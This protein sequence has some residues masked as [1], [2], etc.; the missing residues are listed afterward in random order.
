[1]SYALDNKA[2]KVTSRYVKIRL[3]LVVWKNMQKKKHYTSRSSKKYENRFCLANQI[4]WE[5]H[6]TV[7][8]HTFILTGVG[9]RWYIRPILL[10]IFYKRAIT[11]RKQLLKV[12]NSLFNR[13]GWIHLEITL[14][15]IAI[16]RIVDINFVCLVT[17]PILL[18]NITVQYYIILVQYIKYCQIIGK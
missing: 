16:R 3:K 11:H 6:L 1:M 15:L 10:H 13:K 4:Y 7:N 18:W 2:L 12:F 14:S 5:K 9:L 17:V 8:V